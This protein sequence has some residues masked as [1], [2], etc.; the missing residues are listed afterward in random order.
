MAMGRLPN[1]TQDET[2]KRNG[3]DLGE[4]LVLEQQQLVLHMNI[5]CTQ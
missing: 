4:C 1:V 5:I 2:N 3:L